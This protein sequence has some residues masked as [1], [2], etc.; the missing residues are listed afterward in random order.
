MDATTCRGANTYLD[1]ENKNGHIKERKE[2]MKR[3]S[4]IKLTES[5]TNQNQDRSTRG[6]TT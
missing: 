2:N 1:Q 5:E 3:E 4:D 6:L